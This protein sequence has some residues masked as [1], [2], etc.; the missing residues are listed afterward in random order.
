MV[1]EGV[2]RQWAEFPVDELTGSFQI[3][4]SQMQVGLVFASC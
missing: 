1:Q 3:Q 2:S 4:C